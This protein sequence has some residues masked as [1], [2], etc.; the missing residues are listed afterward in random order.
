MNEPRITARAD[1]LCRA[2]AGDVDSC[3]A[4]VAAGVPT[5]SVGLSTIDTHSL[6]ATPQQGCDLAQG[7][8]MEDP[9]HISETGADVVRDLIRKNRPSED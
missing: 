4:C 1:R 5:C 8:D 9:T 7:G 6:C 3:P 2:V